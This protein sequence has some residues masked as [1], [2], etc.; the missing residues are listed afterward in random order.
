MGFVWSVCTKGSAP[1]VRTR[2][3]DYLIPFRQ[4]SV[5]CASIKLARLERTQS[6]CS[7]GIYC[8]SSEF[9]ISE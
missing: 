6:Y 3:D 1:A 2:K 7:V 9:Q 4:S 8:S 5:V